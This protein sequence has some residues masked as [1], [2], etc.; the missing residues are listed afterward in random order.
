MAAEVG[1]TA[2]LEAQSLADVDATLLCGISCH[3]DEENLQLP[4]G[5]V[6]NYDGYHYS[7]TWLLSIGGMPIDCTIASFQK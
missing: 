5:V 3:S 1:V 2:Q 4:V 7:L 6:Y